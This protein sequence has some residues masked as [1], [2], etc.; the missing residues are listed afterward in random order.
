MAPTFNEKF[1]K[2]AAE[3]MKDKKCTTD[4]IKEHQSKLDALASCNEKPG[5]MKTNPT[6]SKLPVHTGGQSK[7]PVEPKRTL[8]GHI[9]KIQGMGWGPTEALSKKLIASDQGGKIMI[10]DAGKVV[11]EKVISKTFIMTTELHPDGKR[12]FIG[13]MDNVVYVYD[14]S[15][16]DITPVQKQ[17]LQGHDGYIASIKFPKPDVM[18]TAGGDANIIKWD[19]NTNKKVQYMTGHTGD[20][21]CLRFARDKAANPNQFMTCSSDRTARLWDMNSGKSTHIFPLSDEANAGAMFPNGMMIAVGCH[22][23]RIH[24]YDIRSSLPLTYPLL[25]KNNRVAAL[26]FSKSGRTMIAAYEDGHVGMWDPFKHFDTAD[27]TQYDHK[28]DCHFSNNDGTDKIISK[29]EFNYD[30]T[31]FATGAYDSSIKIWAP[32]CAEGGK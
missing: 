12:A 19:L 25:R 20:A 30:G 5:S 17:A 15:G 21:S 29:A 9:R 18:V 16:S 32:K 2:D 24:M 28:V 14:Y 22:D 4:I 10:W 26:D 23:G 31:A 11:K 13:G 7:I 3:Q 6:L 1:C 27:K 8:V